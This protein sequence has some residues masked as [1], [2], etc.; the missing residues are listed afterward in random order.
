[1]NLAPKVETPTSNLDLVCPHSNRHA[2][3]LLSS[4]ESQ[5][6]NSESEE[7]VQGLIK[8][9]LLAVE[10]NRLALLYSDLKTKH[11]NLVEQSEELASEVRVYLKSNAML[12]SQ[13]NQPPLARGSLPV[14][15]NS[16]FFDKR[17]PNQPDQPI[18]FVDEHDLTT[19]PQNLAPIEELTTAPQD[20]ARA[21]HHSQDSA[22]TPPRGDTSG[23]TPGHENSDF[24]T[25]HSINSFQKRSG[26]L[27]PST[28]PLQLESPVTCLPQDSAPTLSTDDIICNLDIG[29]SLIQLKF[30]GILFLLSTE[31]ERLRYC[32]NTQ[33]NEYAQ[34]TQDLHERIE[35]LVQQ[36]QELEELV[37]RLDE[38]IRTADT[39]AAATDASVAV[40]K[41]EGERSLVERV[42]V[43][44]WAPP[45]KKLRFRE[46]KDTMTVVT[47]VDL[48]SRDQQV[49]SLQYKI[50]ELEEVIQSMK[51]ELDQHAEKD[52]EL[53]RESLSV[54]SLSTQVMRVQE[55]LEEKTKECDSTNEELLRT[56]GELQQAR[57][58]LN[59]QKSAVTT[60]EAQQEDLDLKNH[61]LDQELSSEKQKCKKLMA[62]L[63]TER[64]KAESARVE[65]QKRSSLETSKITKSAIQTSTA[66]IQT[67][68]DLT[69]VTQAEH[70]KL[71]EDLEQSKKAALDF[72]R[73]MEQ[74]RTQVAE[75]AIEE[76]EAV[77]KAAVKEFEAKDAQISSLTE[78]LKVV[79]VSLEKYKAKESIEKFEKSTE[80]TAVVEQPENEQ[81]PEHDQ[82]EL[83]K[84]IQT[85]HQELVGKTQEVL[86]VKEDLEQTRT[87]L[88]LAAG[89]SFKK[90]KDLEERKAEINASHEKVRGLQEKLDQQRTGY[91]TQI[92]D[93]RNKLTDALSQESKLKDA[94]VEL[95]KNVDQS[96]IAIQTLK[97]KCLE[98]TSQIGSLNQELGAYKS[99]NEK[100]E[101]E[102]D[103]L[104][105]QYREKA[106]DCKITDRKID[107]LQQKYEK[108]QQNV[109]GL[110]LELRKL[111][112]QNSMLNKQVN[113]S[114]DKLHSQEDNS[115]KLEADL[116]QKQK[117]IRDLEVEIGILRE[118]IQSQEEMFQHSLQTPFKV[119]HVMSEELQGPLPQEQASPQ[120]YRSVQK[121]VKETPP[122]E[123]PPLQQ[124]EVVFLQHMT[125]EAHSEIKSSVSKPFDIL[126]SQLADSLLQSYLPAKLTPKSVLPNLPQIPPGELKLPPISAKE[127]QILSKKVEDYTLKLS[128]ANSL[129]P[130][131]SPNTPGLSSIQTLEAAL[132]QEAALKTRYQLQ[133]DKLKLSKEL[134]RPESGTRTAS[135][136]PDLAQF[137]QDLFE[138][139]RT[140]REQADKQAELQFRRRQI[141]EELYG[142]IVDTCRE[143]SANFD[144][145]VA[146]LIA[147]LQELRD[148]NPNFSNVGQVTRVAGSTR[149]GGSH[150]QPA[151]TILD[152]SPLRDSNA[153]QRQ[154]PL[155]AF[156]YSSM[157]P[158]FGLGNA[159][160][161]RASV[162]IPRPEPPQT[163]LQHSTGLK[164]FSLK[165]VA[166]HVEAVGTGKMAPN[167][168]T[169]LLQKGGMTFGSLDS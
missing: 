123:K 72:Q 29:A 154:D 132:S 120:F 12:Q 75:A 2:L 141:L 86:R 153:G 22:T 124:Q 136:Q 31:T 89:D 23:T 73:E 80:C 15:Q 110:Q 93:L 116:Q 155:Q 60:L 56:L 40:R 142:Q 159:V 64:Q 74:V 99:A 65:E 95:R 131:L 167:H 166:T 122:F 76:I 42:G 108:S 57:D 63:A 164:N 126:S 145:G 121:L 1:M 103:S 92:G 37:F 78:Q 90:D 6:L 32:L 18:L 127:Q 115:Q 50:S 46:E 52:A 118:K 36:N 27:R 69:T 54:E 16:Q 88:R 66:A 152:F 41:D 106:E 4:K 107:D 158:I 68:P 134:F 151:N 97:Q 94:I 61:A 147:E 71:K 55:L 157:A 70:Q 87:D 25:P 91:E 34:M 130:K 77:Q 3:K 156:G 59:K 112:D 8:E 165:K 113:I 58:Q 82:E 24:R 128:K 13:A 79:E 169:D 119:K 39:V 47:E 111:E 14:L 45:R 140:A 139:E 49:V 168:K 10:T 44:N 21:L 148:Q 109:S 162:E 84:Q 161:N 62:E 11:H 104:L 143:Q 9:F 43:L 150:G 33:D 30:A 26:T 100:Q 98:L 20:P 96:L 135:H 7:A 17:E 129:F 53:L 83:I 163:F 67:D 149:S 101:K 19:S 146:A 81:Q 138:S 117:F 85:L 5:P 38:R 133:L 125:P 51:R 160:K 28:V 35:G 144:Q 114:T 48:E 102:L 137:Y 105:E